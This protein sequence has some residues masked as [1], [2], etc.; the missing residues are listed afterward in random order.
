M[1]DDFAEKLTELMA[2]HVDLIP[3][4][5]DLIVI[6]KCLKRVGDQATNI[7]EDVVYAISAEETRHIR[8]QTG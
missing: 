4:Y 1:N 8:H 6:S 3:S 5:V 7:G 2:Y